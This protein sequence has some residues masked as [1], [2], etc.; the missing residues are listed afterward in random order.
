MDTNQKQNA[1][2]ATPNQMEQGST[3]T[4]S[5]ENNYQISTR[6]PEEAE[7]TPTGAASITP[8]QEEEID[9]DILESR[10]CAWLEDKGITMA[11]PRE[12]EWSFFAEKK[13]K[14]FSSI[15][16]GGSLRRLRLRKKGS[17]LLD[18]RAKFKKLM[19]KMKSFDTSSTK[20]GLS[21]SLETNNTARA[22]V[23]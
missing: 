6:A 2:L 8:R 9:I 16:L 12:K 21:L 7:P 1:L 22:Q 10:I 3:P 23:Y 14:S 17:S 20:S 5:I 15:N 11:D 13:V 4:N 19:P 18:R